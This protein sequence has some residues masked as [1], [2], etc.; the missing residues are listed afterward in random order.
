MPCPQNN[1]TAHGH[2]EKAEDRECG[3]GRRNTIG[4]IRLILKNICM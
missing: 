1:Q 3:E 2:K 4:G